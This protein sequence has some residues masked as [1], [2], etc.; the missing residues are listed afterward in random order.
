MKSQNGKRPSYG[1]SPIHAAL[2]TSAM[3]AAAAVESRRMP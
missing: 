2:E 3:A 1:R